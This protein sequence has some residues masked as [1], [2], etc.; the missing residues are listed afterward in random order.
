MAEQKLGDSLDL[1]SEEL[2]H[3]KEMYEQ[4][5][6]LEAYTLMKKNKILAMVLAFFCAPISYA[7]LKKYEYLFI[8]ILTLNYCLLG[9]IIAPLHLY[10]MFNQAEQKLRGI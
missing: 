9:F 7:Y 5:D 6:L 2:V 10:Y 3:V 1:N 4:N 8:S